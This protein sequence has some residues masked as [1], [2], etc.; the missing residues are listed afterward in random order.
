MVWPDR[1]ATGS[2]LAAGIFP[3]LRPLLH[4]GV[5]FGRAL[6]R[7]VAQRNFG[8]GI[9]SDVYV[10]WYHGDGVPEAQSIPSG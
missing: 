2:S 9:S 3:E 7:G 10:S 6:H 1:G 4:A 8:P 5:C